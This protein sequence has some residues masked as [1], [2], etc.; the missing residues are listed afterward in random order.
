M[1]NIACRMPQI[2]SARGEDAV[3]RVTGDKI[4]GDPPNRVFNGAFSSVTS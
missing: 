2:Y 4:A 1:K 3:G